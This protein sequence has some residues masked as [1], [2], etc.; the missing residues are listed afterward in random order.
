[1]LLQM[2]APIARIARRVDP[3]GPFGPPNIKHT[4]RHRNDVRG[5]RILLGHEEHE[6]LMRP[7]AG[8]ERRQDAV[9]TNAGFRCRGDV[10]IAGQWA[11][12][13]AGLLAVRGRVTDVRHNELKDGAAVVAR[14]RPYPSRAS[15]YGRYR[16][17]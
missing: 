1:M 15:P 8:L 4:E 11:E 16:W 12:R 3:F 17:P 9:G 2:R 7:S 5:L 14:V 10:E 6:Q 13:F